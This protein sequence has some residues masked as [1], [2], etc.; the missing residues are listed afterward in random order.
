[1]MKRLLFGIILFLQADNF[2][3]NDDNLYLVDNT[4]TTDSEATYT[5]A[6]I[7]KLSLLTDAEELI[8]CGS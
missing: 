7:T 1:M 4:I 3:L 8:E 6:L 5:D 2:V